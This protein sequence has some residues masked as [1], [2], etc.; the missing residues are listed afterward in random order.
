MTVQIDTT[1]VINAVRLAQQRSAPSAP[2]SGYEMLYII[3]G[4]VNGG[5]FLKDSSGEAYGPFIPV[6]PLD[7]VTAGVGG[8]LFIG[9]GTYSGWSDL[10]STPVTSV[11]RSIDGYLI[12]RNTGNTGAQSRGSKR[13]YS[14]SGDFSVITKIP[15]TDLGAD[16]QWAG[17]FIGA[18][19]PS[20][21]GSGHRLEL[22]LLRNSVRQWKFNK[23]DAGVGTSVFNTNLPNGDGSL[24]CWLRIRRS[25]STIFAG[26]S[27][28]G[29]E[30][31]ESA[32]TTTI[33]F[34]VAT[35]GLFLS[36]STATNNIK[37]IF[38]Y[39]VT[40]P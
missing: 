22:F 19:D 23:V 28:D 3:S 5:L 38:E 25:G 34:T 13:S 15:Y 18:A 39:I 33:S 8:D 27:F 16:F 9:T 21:G 29:I 36:E 11:D 37:T 30:F 1:A 2:A 17:L 24:P 6:L 4:S 14:P 35:C 10:Q 32:T 31:N 7:N 20:D 26:I 40:T 12:L